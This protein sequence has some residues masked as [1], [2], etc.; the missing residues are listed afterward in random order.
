MQVKNTYVETRNIQ[1]GREDLS[2]VQDTQRPR[3]F[4][5]DL[6]SRAE[7]VRL[8]LPKDKAITITVV[9]GP[10]KGLAHRVVKPR[11]SIGR[12]GGGAD[13]E[14]GDPQV[15]D[16]HCAVGVNGD[17]IRLCDLDSAHGTYVNDERV[18]AAT[19]G[20]LSEFRVGSSLLLVIILPTLEVRGGEPDE[21]RDNRDV[22]LSGL[23]V[24]SGTRG[25]PSGA[26]VVATGLHERKFE[27]QAPGVPLGIATVARGGR[28]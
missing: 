11:I 23:S 4:S 20:H 1:E 16:L 24:L 15:S 21:K 5:L 27:H 28:Q 17:I 25:S 8:A 2:P 7:R 9:G 14:L 12:T 10:S 18:P 13:I 19:L 26:T 6:G 3:A 22:H